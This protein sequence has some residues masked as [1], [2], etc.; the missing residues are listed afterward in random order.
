MSKELHETKTAQSQLYSGL[1]S[2]VCDY[3][4]R[5][6]ETRSLELETVLYSTL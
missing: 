1:S 3:S 5:Q 2:T 4:I 6:V